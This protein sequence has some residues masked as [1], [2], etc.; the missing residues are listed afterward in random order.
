MRPQLIDVLERSPVIAAIKNDEG[1]EAARASDCHVALMLTGSV[2][3]LPDRVA[4]LKEAG[5]IVIVH[6]D[7]IAGLS[8]K[9]VAV[10]YI[11]EVAGADG[12]ISTKN[13]LV[14][15]GQSIGLY[16]IQRTFAVDSIALS[17]LKKQ[18]KTFQP[19]AVEIL[20][21][22]VPRV[23]AEVKKETSIPVIAGGLLADK[24]DIMDAFNAGADAVSTTLEELWRT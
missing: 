23:I 13:P 11:R 22:I 3:D 2:I 1:F 19:D 8:A 20:P 17:T 9:E 14:R 6:A 7:M 10:D 21:G 18:L 15:H 5:K 24:R 4:S 16:A 12:M